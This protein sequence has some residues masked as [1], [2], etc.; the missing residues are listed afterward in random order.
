[1]KRLRISIKNKQKKN[2]ESL[3]MGEKALGYV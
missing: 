1:M 2:K 3:T